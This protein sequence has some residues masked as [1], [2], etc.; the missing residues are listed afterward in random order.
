M[1]EKYL[2]GNVKRTWLENRML[3]GSLMNEYM[4]PLSGEPF[5]IN[6]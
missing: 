4:K 5:E 1:I 6:E 2:N 3:N